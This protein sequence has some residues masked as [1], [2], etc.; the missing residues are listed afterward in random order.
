MILAKNDREWEVRHCRFADDGR[1]FRKR[2]IG[3]ASVLNLPDATEKS[4]E[5]LSQI[6]TLCR[7]STISV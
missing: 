6:S 7:T 3:H 5:A 2:L 4:P 1:D